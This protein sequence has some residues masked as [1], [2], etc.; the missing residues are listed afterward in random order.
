[1]AHCRSSRPVRFRT[2]STRHVRRESGVPAKKRSRGEDLT[3]NI[4]AAAVGE[5][6]LAIETRLRQRSCIVTGCQLEAAES[7]G[8]AVPMI[9]T[10]GKAQNTQTKKQRNM[11][12]AV[13]RAAIGS[14]KMVE[15]TLTEIER[16]SP[17]VNART[18]QNTVEIVRISFAAVGAVAIAKTI[19]I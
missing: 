15:M 4:E 1:M 2:R 17:L 12:R 13:D 16:V 8:V 9:T 3:G 19:D 18:T 7:V 14:G 6:D 11:K 5:R 10:D